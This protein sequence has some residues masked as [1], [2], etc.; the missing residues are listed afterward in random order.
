MYIIYVNLYTS[1]I[2]I[3]YDI[4]DT[5]IVVAHML[6]YADM[7]VMNINNDCHGYW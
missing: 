2:R 5:L 6:N 4:V 3:V 1:G 7:A